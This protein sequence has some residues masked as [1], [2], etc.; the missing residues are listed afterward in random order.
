VLDAARLAAEKAG[1]SADK[2]VTEAARASLEA[3]ESVHSEKV[4]AQ[5]RD[6]L[7]S[8]PVARHLLIRSG[9]EPRQPTA[10]TPAPGTN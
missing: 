3:A 4:L 2:A 10:P 1:A 7:W 8:D 9:R 6:A 5:V